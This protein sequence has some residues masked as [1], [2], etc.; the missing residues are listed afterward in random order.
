MSLTRMTFAGL[1]AL[2]FA[3][4]A[5]AG[6]LTV[7]GSFRTRYETVDGQF[8][9][10]RG[11]SDQ[12]L[13][14]RTILFAEYDFGAVR[15]GGE[16]RDA[17]A[18]L[19]DAGGAVSTSEVNAFE[20]VQAYVA[21][22]APGPGGGEASLQAGR[23]LLDLGSRRLVAEN[24]YRNTTNAFT[25][26]RADLRSEA[27][28]A[29]TLFYVLP[30]ERRP[31]SQAD[32]LDNAV[33]ID[34]ER[35]EAAFW[36]AFYARPKSS[37]GLLAE[38]YVFRLGEEDAEG[39]SS[40]DRRLWTVGGRLRRPPSPGRF[41]FEIEGAWQIGEARASTAAADRRDLDVSAGFIHLAAGWT[42][43]AS[44]SPR[45]AAEFQY[46]GGD[47]DPAD[48]DYG[49]FD[50]LFG[51]RRFDFGPTGIYGPLS[52]A[53]IVSPG[54]RLEVK[55]DRRLDAMAAYRAAWTAEPADAFANTGLR[56]GSGERFAGH[57][58]EARARYW[59]TPDRVRL[60]VGGAVLWKG[61]MLQRP[62]EP[63][64]T[65]AGYVE[66]TTSF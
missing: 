19:T 17:R 41:D 18:Y 21:L 13:A 7:E 54:L 45:I 38:A 5:Q 12:I 24:S 48:G 20:P 58:V 52:R 14:L 30:Q 65:L 63:D 10:G 3:G 29:L 1:I 4:V 36:G 6:E 66:M 22:D 62:G 2:A 23:F 25:G 11:G 42:L 46:A 56:A 27:A 61:E 31:S 28:G 35:P 15:V 57:Q 33:Q 26:L 43:D 40:R 55:P 9:A 44:W 49:R 47:A 34:R 51:A 8:R 16:L 64:R 32:L 39:F 59:I 53:N 50:T 60:E 37:N